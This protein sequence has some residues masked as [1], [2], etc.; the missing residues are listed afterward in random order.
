[1]EHTHLLGYFL[2]SGGEDLQIRERRDA[3]GRSLG[4]VDLLGYHVDYNPVT[5]DSMLRE[6]AVASKVPLYPI[7]E[8][9][10]QYADTYG[11]IGA[12]R[13]NYDL[14]EFKNVR[15]MR[16]DPAPGLG[17]E[18]DVLYQGIPYALDEHGALRPGIEYGAIAVALL[19]KWVVRNARWTREYDWS[20][21]EIQRAP[22]A[23]SKHISGRAAAAVA[24]GPV[25]VG[26][27][28]CALL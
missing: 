2:T 1:M 9:V 7:D 3:A 11:P 16:C 4:V 6:R 14:Q 28:V 24:V 21:S 26:A 13:N 27:S 8:F 17:L 12:I 25:G 18:G 10:A 5:G 15:W 23:Y 20:F 19:F 22:P